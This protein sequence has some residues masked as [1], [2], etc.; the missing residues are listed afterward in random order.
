VKTGFE[1]RTLLIATMHGKEAAIAPPL[2]AALGV[3]C[4]LPSGFDT[5]RFGTYSGETERPGNAFETMRMKCL[6]AMEACGADLGIASEG[7]FGPHPY[8]PFAVAGEERLICIDRLQ[9]LEI[10]V[11]QVTPRTNF[12]R[13]EVKHWQALM[14]FARQAGF[15]AHGLLLKGLQD[16]QPVCIKGIQSEAA[17]RIAFDRLLHE[18]EVVTVETD[19]RAMCNPTRMDVIAQLTQ[20]LLDKMTSLCPACAKPGFGEKRH[21]AGLPCGWCGSPTGKVLAA[22]TN[23]TH[24]GFGER[25]VFPDGMEEADPGDC[26]RCNP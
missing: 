8:I 16:K 24:C 13:E 5:D 3:R 23:C 4:I 12:N 2:E 19:M 11:Q 10:A 14:D 25:K 15:P 6:A 18:N 26:P 22:E 20:Q 17:L 7:S 21:E 1:G 9:G